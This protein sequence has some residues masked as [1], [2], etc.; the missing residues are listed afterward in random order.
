MPINKRS[1]AS[2]ITVHAYR[3]VHAACYCRGQEQGPQNGF[4]VSINIQIHTFVVIFPQ[5][6]IVILCKTNIH[7]W[8]PAYQDS[9]S[10]KDATVRSAFTSQ[11]YRLI[12]TTHRNFST[13]E[14]DCRSHKTN[15]WP[16]AEAKRKREGCA[17]A[18]N[19][20]G[21]RETPVATRLTRAAAF[22]KCVCTIC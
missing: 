9:I 19:L 6:L 15:T 4:R 1:R 2:A 5:I 21:T 22:A 10:C 12:T 14:G 3:L 18:A 8:I 20:C 17:L 11:I 16:R 13:S 7:A